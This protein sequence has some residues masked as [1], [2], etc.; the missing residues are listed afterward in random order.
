MNI[1]NCFSQRW[2]SGRAASGGRS[3]ATFRGHLSNCFTE[4]VANWQARVVSEV[5]P[6]FATMFDGIDH[7]TVRCVVQSIWQK[8]YHFYCNPNQ[9]PQNRPPRKV[10]A[11]KGR[12]RAREGEPIEGAAA[13]EAAPQEQRGRDIN[14]DL[15]DINLP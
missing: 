14:A 6:T 7:S 8:Y 3:A 5:L 9:P 4:A 12:K 10:R 15:D 2:T 11:D 13:Q 1:G